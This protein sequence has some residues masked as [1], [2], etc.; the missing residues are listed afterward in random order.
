MGK[1]NNDCMVIRIDKELKEGFEIF[2]REIG[3]TV[4]GAVNLLV[5]N[6]IKQQK[7]PFKITSSNTVKTAYEGGNN[8]TLRTSIRFDENLKMEF[9]KICSEI[10]LPMSCIIKMFMLNCVK[11]GKL[12]F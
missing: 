4:S 8:Q 5:R 7:I 10:G 9:R 11:T 2:C 12:P 1:K 3:I 6:T